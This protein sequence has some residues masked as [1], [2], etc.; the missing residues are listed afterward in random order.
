MSCITRIGIIGLLIVKDLLLLDPQD[1][2]PISTILNLYGR[3]VTKVFDD[4]QLA[5]LLQR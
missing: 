5:D 1:A 3:P 2:I 4:V